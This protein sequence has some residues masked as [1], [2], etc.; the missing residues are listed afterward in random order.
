MNNQYD[1]AKMP[2][3]KLIETDAIK[4][5]FAALLDK[6][7]PQFLSSIASAVSLN[8]RLARVDQL[9]VINSAMVAATLDLP[10]N[11]SLGFVYIV[12]YKNQAQPQIGYKGYIQLAQ[13]SGRYQRLTALPIYEDEFKSWNPLTEELEYTPNFHDREASE[14]P[15]GYAASFKLTNGFEKMVY[16]T[17]QQ[18]DDHRK[19]FSQSG[20]GAEPKGVWKDNY[21][22]MALKTVIKSLLTKWGPMTTDMQS[23]VSADE[24]PV[25]ADPELKDVTPEDP[26][27]IEDALNAPAEPVTK[28]EVKPDALKPDITHDP[29]AGKQTDIFDGQ[30]G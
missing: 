11:P 14:K 24:K 5:K 23:A 10:V 19:R 2:V 21:E 25:E 17:Y 28:S 6:R 12:P 26:N 9:S 3:K 4:N 22:A 8:P 1:L 20:G 16:W 30:Q 15:V 27:S 29:N 13:R 7:A 18:V